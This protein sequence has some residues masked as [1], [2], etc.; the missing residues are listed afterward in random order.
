MAVD[1]DSEEDVPCTFSD[2]LHDC[3]LCSYGDGGTGDS[4]VIVS[5]ME[6]ID[7]ALTGTIQDNEIYAIQSQLY[8]H[9]VQR[10]LE[11]QGITAPAITSEHCKNHFG[12][13]RLNPRRVVANDIR[14]ADT[15]QRYYATQKILS[16]NNQTGSTRLDST[17][18][19][20]WM[21]L[22]KHKLD[23][24]KCYKGV[25]VSASVCRIVPYALR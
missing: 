5:Q 3:P 9:H 1:D 8:T 21:Q 22:S 17:A 10:P 2:D 11:R 24:L 18:M 15:M 16:R 6:D 19:K 4:H 13:H 23:L 12:K 7:D 20:Q 25:V 14:F